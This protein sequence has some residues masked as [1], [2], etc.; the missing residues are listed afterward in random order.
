[1][2]VYTY[3]HIYKH[4]KY[5]ASG[6]EHMTQKHISGTR[7]NLSSLVKAMAH[8]LFGAKPLPDSMMIALIRVPIQNN[9]GIE[10]IGISW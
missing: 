7:S 6:N 10:I 1:M 9:M 3:I 5:L 4:F 2:A 8:R